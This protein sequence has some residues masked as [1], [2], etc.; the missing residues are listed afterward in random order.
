M[1]ASYCLIYFGLRYEIPA[2]KTEPLELRTDPRIAIARRSR[3]NHWWDNFG[4]EGEE[5]LLYVGKE[6]GIV[7][8]EGK[9]EVQLNDDD[10]KALVESTSTKLKDLGYEGSP[11]LYIKWMEDV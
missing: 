6:L 4:G 2:D 3:L 10:F 8:P 5:Y 9:L 1:S 11:K 7:G